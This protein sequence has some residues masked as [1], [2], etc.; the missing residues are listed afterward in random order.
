[1]RVNNPSKRPHLWRRESL[2]V[3]PIGFDLGKIGDRLFERHEAGGRF[4]ITHGTTPQR[5]DVVETRAAEPPTPEDAFI[6]EQASAFSSEMIEA[7]LVDDFE[8]FV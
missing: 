5:H 2:R 3:N 7:A 1:M 4:R 6:D 8:V